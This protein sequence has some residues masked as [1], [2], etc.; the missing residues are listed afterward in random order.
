MPRVRLEPTIP[1][2]EQGKTVHALTRPLWWAVY[3]YGR[4]N[5]IHVFNCAS[6][7]SMMIIL[8]WKEGTAL[9]DLTLNNVPVAKELQLMFAAGP[10]RRL[11]TS[12]KLDRSEFICY[13]LKSIMGNR[14]HIFPSISSSLV[15]YG[16]IITNNYFRIVLNEFYLS[17]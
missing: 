2:F 1:V 12:W 15:D 13:W 9:M 3:M 17:L 4:L 6:I 14:T 7:W 8:I 16:A 5:I 10:F 11:F